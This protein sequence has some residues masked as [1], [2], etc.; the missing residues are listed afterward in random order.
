M[1]SVL[2]QSNKHISKLV[3][4]VF[5]CSVRYSANVQSRSMA[6][7]MLRPFIADALIRSHVSP[8]DLELG[9]VVLWQDFF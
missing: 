5:L 8:Y 6:Q 2:S 4:L 7:L 3:S 1:Q 9:K